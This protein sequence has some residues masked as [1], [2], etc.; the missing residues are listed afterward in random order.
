MRRNNMKILIV[1]DDKNISAIL[2]IAFKNEGFDV[3]VQNNSLLAKNQITKTDYDL[4][5]L[6]IMMPEKNGFDLCKEIREFTTV[7]IVFITCLDDESS[8]ISALELGGDD[9]IKK[10]F[11]LSEVV[12]RVKVHLRRVEQTREM[13][14]PK[15]IVFSSGILVYDKSVVEVTNGTIHLSPLERDLL[16]FFISN[17][18]K[19]LTYKEIYENIWNEPYI[20]DKSTI[21]T[22][23]SNLRNK[24]PQ[25]SLNTVRGKGYIYSEK[26]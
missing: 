8:L 11:N 3:D 18:N 24:I 19:T 10:P 23:I 21:M 7:P 15:R 2:E 4:I 25:L 16:S 6:D 17:Q 26:I 12:M 9:Y 22:R 5:L 20:H 14:T 13:L 1:D